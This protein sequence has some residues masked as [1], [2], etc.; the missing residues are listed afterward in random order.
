MDGH[1]YRIRAGG[2]CPEQPGDRAVRLESHQTVDGV[3]SDHQTGQRADL[4]VQ[5]LYSY[6][7]TALRMIGFGDGSTSSCTTAAYT[8]A[9]VCS[10][11]PGASMC[12]RSV[13]AKVCR[14]AIRFRTTPMRGRGY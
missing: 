11:I 6:D 13:A 5:A 12:W 14:T 1:G 8:A 10:S 4:T 7:I 2:V 9:A 3:Y